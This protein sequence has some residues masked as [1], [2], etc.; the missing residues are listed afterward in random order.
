MRCGFTLDNPGP[1]ALDVWLDRIQLIGT[2]PGAVQFTDGFE[3][4]NTSA[5]SAAVP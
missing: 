2:S 1:D 3:L 5:W 4:G